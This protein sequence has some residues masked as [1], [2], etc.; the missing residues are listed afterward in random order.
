[1]DTLEITKFVILAAFAIAGVYL[2]IKADDRK[3]STH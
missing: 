3:H 1:M 2:A